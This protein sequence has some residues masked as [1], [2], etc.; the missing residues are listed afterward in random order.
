MYQGEL[1][2]PAEI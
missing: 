1:G 2:R